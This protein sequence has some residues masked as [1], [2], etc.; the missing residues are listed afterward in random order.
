MVSSFYSR[1]KFL[2]GVTTGVHFYAE[3]Y[4]TVWESSGATVGLHDR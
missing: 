3:P 1:P 2:T 4:K